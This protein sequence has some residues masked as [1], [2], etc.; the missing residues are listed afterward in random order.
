LVRDAVS[1]AGPGGGYIAG[2][3]N[4]VP[5]YAQPEN[6]CAMQRA[7]RAYGAYPLDL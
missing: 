7:I 5:Y 1:V 2:S 6:V 4:S 3:S